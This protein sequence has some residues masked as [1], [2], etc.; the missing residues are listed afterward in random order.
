MMKSKEELL[1]SVEGNGPGGAAFERDKT[2]L[3]HRDAEELGAAIDRLDSTL[4]KASSDA[5][6]LSGRLSWLNVVIAVATLVGGVATA[7]QAYVA[8][9]KK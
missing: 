1:A 6:R 9:F 2:L 4:K 8:L 5:D 7:I 3:L